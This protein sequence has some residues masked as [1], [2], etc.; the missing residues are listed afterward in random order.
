M[1]P[2]K[3]KNGQ[4]LD[5]HRSIVL[6]SGRRLPVLGRFVQMVGDAPEQLGPSFERNDLARRRLGQALQADVRSQCHCDTARA[7]EETNLLR[8]SVLRQTKQAVSTKINEPS[9][10]AEEAAADQVQRYASS[11]TSC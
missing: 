8:S 10:K 1:A 2:V 11:Y 7:Q 5:V 4:Y 6:E 9:G 3:G